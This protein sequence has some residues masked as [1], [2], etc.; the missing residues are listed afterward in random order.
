MK[1]FSLIYQ[2]EVHP[3]TDEKII[4]AESYS[5]LLDAAQVLEKAQE[6][7]KRLIEE[8][9]AEGERMREAARQEGFEEGLSKLNDA[10]MTL[11]GGV[12][13]MEHELQRMVLPLAMS[14]A[15]KIVAHE[16]ESSPETIVDIVM[17]ALA[18]ATQSYRVTIFVS[19]KDKELIEKERPKIAKI[20]PHVQ[21]LNIQERAD[22]AP[23][24]CIIQTEKG[25]INAELENQWTALERAFEKY[26]K[27][28]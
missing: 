22:I 4:P 21:V 19:K 26:F 7:A 25:M 6:D 27:N 28:Q 12:K 8:A 13:R 16:L 20:L 2:G 17:Q 11:D 18:P 23:G 24:G 9:Q 10:I 15:K 14:A 3:S 1:F 5:T